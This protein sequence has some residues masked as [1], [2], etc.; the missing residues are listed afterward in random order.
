MTEMP[1]SAAEQAFGGGLSQR[2]GRPGLGR[3]VQIKVTHHFP[4]S[5]KGK[6]R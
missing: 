1:D 3:Y 2:G 5:R 4:P 6:R